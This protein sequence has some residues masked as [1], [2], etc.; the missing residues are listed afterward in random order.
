MLILDEPTAALTSDEAERLFA[1][2][3]QLRDQGIIVLYIT[4][5]MG[6]V[7]RLADRVTILK[8][9]RLVQTFDQRGVTEAEIIPL[10]V[11]REISQMFPDL[12]APGEDV[13][14]EA[15]DLEL[16][17]ELEG[18]SLAVRSGEIVGVAGLEGSGKSAF[19][20]VLAGSEASRAG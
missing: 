11:G 8:D 18:V 4:H 14:L 17:A 1:L 15:R 19:A 7:E 5:R 2:L 20:R 13:I 3:V 12:A 9:G 6:E 16:P 10:M